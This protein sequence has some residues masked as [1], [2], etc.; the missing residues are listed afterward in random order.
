M[1]SAGIA[2][3]LPNLLWGSRDNWVSLSPEIQS[4][5]R[6]VLVVDVLGENSTRMEPAAIHAAVSTLTVHPTRNPKKELH[7]YFCKASEFIDQGRSIGTVF[8]HDYS[9][10]G[11]NAVVFLCAYM[12]HLGLK[13]KDAW[14]HLEKKV[15]KEHLPYATL[16]PDWQRLMM[17]FE[18]KEGISNRENRKANAALLG[19]SSSDRTFVGPN[20]E[21]EVCFQSFLYL[22]LACYEFRT[23]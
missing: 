22:P 20:L 10:A 2:Y 6:S 16:N 19:L 5:C 21:W 13:Y 9:A 4:A 14:N 7:I 11:E 8:V 1:E 3:I 15:G 18:D 17:E 23:L 12:M